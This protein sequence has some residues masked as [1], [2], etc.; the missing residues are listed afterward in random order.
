MKRTSAEFRT[1]FNFLEFKFNLFL[2]QNIV[3]K[4]MKKNE[5]TD[6]FQVNFGIFFFV[7]KQKF[8]YFKSCRNS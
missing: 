2:L 5:Q 1:E 7:R 8:V 6:K 3:R 4:N